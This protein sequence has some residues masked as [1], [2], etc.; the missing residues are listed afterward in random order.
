VERRVYLIP[1]KYIILIMK[2][3]KKTL[4]FPLSMASLA[5]LTTLL[6]LDAIHKYLKNLCNRSQRMPT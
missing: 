4:T 6:T 1:T 5:I 2:V 3:K